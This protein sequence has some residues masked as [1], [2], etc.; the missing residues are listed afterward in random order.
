[1]SCC[2]LSSRSSF[3]HGSGSDRCEHGEAVL[4][5]RRTR[6]NVIVGLRRESSRAG[7]ASPSLLS[8]SGSYR[9]NGQ[10]PLVTVASFWCAHHASRISIPLC[11]AR[12]V[13]E[14]ERRRPDVLLGFLGTPSDRLGRVRTHRHLRHVHV[15][16]RHGDHGR[17][18]SCAVGLAAGGELGDRR[19]G[20]GLGGLAAGGSSTPRCRARGCSR[21]ARR[22]GRGRGRRTR[23]R[24]PS[25]HRP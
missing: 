16:V 1:M 13:G 9:N 24:R 19:P 25:R 4:L 23:C 15:A 18:P 17:G 2:A 6:L 5:R 21:C 12:A 8:R 22:R 3:G 11:D 20:R 14:D 7:R 10:Y